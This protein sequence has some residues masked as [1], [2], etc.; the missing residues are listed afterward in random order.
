MDAPNSTFRRSLLA[1]SLLVLLACGDV[2]ASTGGGGGGAGVGA[3]EPLECA[4]AETHE[5]EGTFY[6][7]A[8]GSGNCGF[9]ATPDDLLVAA[10]NQTD[11]AAS[12]ACGGCIRATG[13]EGEVTVRVV[14]R[15]PECPAG[16]VDF[17]PEAFERLAP[18]SAGRVPI[19]WH[20]VACDVDG[21]LTYHFKDGSNPYWTA[22]QVRNHRH[23]VASFAF[24][25]S[26][27]EWV[28][29][30][31]VDYNYF[32]YDQGMGDGPYDFRV[33]DVYGGVVEDTGIALGDDVDR[34]GASQLPVC[35]G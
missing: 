20:W 29:V 10:M 23:L 34:S 30:P 28:D 32:V 15:C 4:E 24:R 18:L 3:G 25:V 12:A 11:Y 8:D 7:F 5:G 1:S 27:G 26:G 17:S 33:T 22:V 9:P 13:P 21:P 35:G 19:G 2:G 31:R 14:D 6:D 16:D